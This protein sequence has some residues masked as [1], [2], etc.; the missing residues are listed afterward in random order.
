MRTAA[1]PVRGPRSCNGGI[2]ARVRLLAVLTPGTTR[3]AEGEARGARPGR[4]PHPTRVARRPGWTEGRHPPRLQPRA[5][6]VPTRPP[7][8]SMSKRA[9]PEATATDTSGTH[10][11]GTS[12]QYPAPHARA[13]GPRSSPWSRILSQEPKTA[14]APGPAVQDRRHRRR[15]I[16]RRRGPP[17]QG[18]APSR[19]PDGPPS[20][21]MRC[22]RSRQ[23]PSPEQGI[24]AVGIGQ[25][26]ARQP[27]TIHSLMTTLRTP[28][29]SQPPQRRAPASASRRRCPSQSKGQQS[30]Q[31]ASAGA[32]SRD[33]RGQCTTRH[34]ETSSRP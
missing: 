25:W 4:G 6:R 19:H 27:D 15:L 28:P 8:T 11:N 22:H 13:G 30:P 9:R 17:P 2:A 20:H 3:V 1:G 16:S 18:K 32:S 23:W 34:P 31:R 12:T 33:N 7:S 10:P 24:W 14:A 5:P 29:P 26:A 21:L